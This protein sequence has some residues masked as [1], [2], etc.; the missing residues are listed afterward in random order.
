MIKT[1]QNHLKNKKYFVFDFD[2]TLAQMEIDWSNWH[3]GIANIYSKYDLDHG[4][5]LGENPHKHHNNLVKKYGE[6]L[7]RDAQ[8]FNRDYEAE[9]LTGFTPNDELIQF[10]KNNTSPTFY[11][12][13]SNSKP[14]VIKGLTELGIL[15]KVKA[16]VSKDDVTFVKPNPEGFDLFDNF[17][18]NQSLFLMI[19]DSTADRDVAKAAGV[20]F[21]ECN[22]FKKYTEEE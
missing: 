1:L 12:Y 22:I 21:L 20:D 11:V 2:R 7:L 16:I 10:I 4:Y 18:G 8:K 14:T 6:P 17:K 3:T 19:G 13:S 9:Y 15:D 5:K